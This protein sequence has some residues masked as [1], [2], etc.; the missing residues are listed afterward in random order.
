MPFYDLVCKKC[1]KEFNQKASISERE[2][3][4]IECPECGSNEL[5]PVFKNVNII[6]SRTSSAPQCPNI[7][8]CGG[9]CPHNH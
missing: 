2:S 9:C 3:K 7:N 4:S 1:G 6:K 5:D 8:A